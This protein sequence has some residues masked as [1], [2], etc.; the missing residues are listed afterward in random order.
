MECNAPLYHAVI[1]HITYFHAQH[2]F[3]M[4]VLKLR[5][6]ALKII[7][8]LS[9]APTSTFRGSFY[10]LNPPEGCT[11]PLVIDLYFQ[12]TLIQVDITF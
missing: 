6:R 7:T 11:G 5:P 3:S 9:A 2:L 1:K 12:Y 4:S 8:D 10:F